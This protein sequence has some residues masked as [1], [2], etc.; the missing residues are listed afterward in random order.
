MSVRTSGPATA[1]PDLLILCYHA[2][3]GAWDC[4]LAVGPHELEAQ[5]R[6]A[7]RRG[8]APMTLSQ[9]LDAGAGERRL[10]VSFDDAYR[11]V[12]REALP[13][14]SALGVPGSVFVPTDVAAEGGLMTDAISMPAEWTASEEELRCMSWEEL[15][16]LAEAGWEIG[17]HTCSHPNLTQLG[18][19]AAAAELSRSRRACEEELQR[20]CRSLAYPYGAH[21]AGVVE[22][23]REAGYEWAVTLG[24]R[25]LEPLASPSALEL[26]RDGVYRS[27]RRW[28]FALSVSPPL[29]R[30]RAT[31][32]YGA[33]FGRRRPPRAQ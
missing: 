5:I 25:L 26:P 20:P 15:R 28:E 16:G 21:D 12:L 10:V 31:Q 7:L 13:L 33:A 4:V 14:M 1:D 2:V 29:R 18:A 3:S 8:Y 23:A 9:A 27:T 19:A 6:H 17:S 30:V 24:H 32:A 11:S 22:R